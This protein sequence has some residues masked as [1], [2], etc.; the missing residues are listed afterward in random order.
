MT[1]LMIQRSHDLVINTT[2]LGYRRGDPAHR[3]RLNTCSAKASL[4][5][6]II[7]FIPGKYGRK[8]VPV[9]TDPSIDSL[10][11]V[12]GMP[13]LATQPRSWLRLRPT[14]RLEHFGHV[15]PQG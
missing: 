6:C 8:L 3:L 11:P 10:L 14:V 13:A 12:A 1:G 9:D 4:I 5:N 15:H 2:K 7:T